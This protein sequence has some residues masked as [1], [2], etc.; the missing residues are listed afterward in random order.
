MKVM[1]QEIYAAANN[2]GRENKGHFLS[3]IDLL[4]SRE[5][6]SVNVIQM[7]YIV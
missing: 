6:L 3:L 1:D 2:K 4:E 5:S 7:Q